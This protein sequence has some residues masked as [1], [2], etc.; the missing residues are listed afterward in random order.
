MRWE[1]TPREPG[2]VA[3]FNGSAQAFPFSPGTYIGR[4][5]AHGQPVVLIADESESQFRPD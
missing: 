2:F 4:T 3:H 1:M 5:V